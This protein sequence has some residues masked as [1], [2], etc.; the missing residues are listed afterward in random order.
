MRT[1]LQTFR[2]LDGGPIVTVGEV[3]ADD[4]PVVAAH[5]A[6]FGPSDEPDES[7]PSDELPPAP[8]LATK[9]PRK[10]AP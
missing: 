1:A 9:T 6:L 7:A 4:H 10:A 8:A 3:Y 2:P 5:E